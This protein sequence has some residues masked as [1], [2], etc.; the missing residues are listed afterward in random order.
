MRRNK[1]KT[2]RE[3]CFCAKYDE[4]LDSK[5]ERDDETKSDETRARQNKTR[6]RTKR[7]MKIKHN[8]WFWETQ[9]DAKSETRDEETKTKLNAF[10][11]RRKIEL[12]WLYAKIVSCRRDWARLNF[13]LKSSNETRLS[14]SCKQIE[15]VLSIEAS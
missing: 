14:A 8:L 2:R 10:W 6:T 11:T 12:D 15:W 13:I 5:F 7:T 4:E 1:T 9:E 3:V